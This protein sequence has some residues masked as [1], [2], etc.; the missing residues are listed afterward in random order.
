MRYIRKLIKNRRA[1]LRDDLISALITAKEAS[2]SLSD[3]EL[4][5]MI[6]LLI[7]AGHETT[8]NLIASGM[9][10][11]L[12]HPD[13]LER[14]RSDPGL[15]KPAVEE[16]LRYTAPVETSTERYARYHSRAEQA[17]GVRPGNSFL[18]RRVASA[19]GGPNCDQYPAGPHAGLTT[20]GRPQYAALAQR[21]CVARVKGTA[22]LVHDRSSNGRAQRVGRR[23]S[24]LGWNQR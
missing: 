20:D 15:I 7:V 14:L 1:N 24:R 4:L 10:A 21:S 19:A 3:D 5:S 2:E 6:L 16:L 18:P 23:H 12:E 9:L 22:R 13:Q 8:V 17:P 11:L